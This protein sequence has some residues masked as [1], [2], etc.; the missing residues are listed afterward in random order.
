MVPFIISRIS[1]MIKI[2]DLTDHLKSEASLSYSA[3]AGTNLRLDGLTDLKFVHLIEPTSVIRGGPS[4]H[5]LLEALTLKG[6]GEAF[7]MERLEILG[8]AFLKYSVSLAL[9]SNKVT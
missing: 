7:N 9:F 8:D 5:D 4:N 6:A 2:T 3:V 1:S